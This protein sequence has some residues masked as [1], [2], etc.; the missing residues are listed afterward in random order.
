MPIENDRQAIDDLLDFW[1]AE[2]T[3]AR[4]YQSTDAFDEL[5]WDRFGDLTA[6]AAGGELAHWEETAKGALAVC[7]LLD[8]MPRNLHRGTPK[9]FETDPEAVA[10]S[11][12]AI[13]RAL[14]QELDIERRKFLYM[15]FMHS[16]HLD[17]Q[18][19]CVALAKALNDENMVQHA[20]EHADIVRRFGRF[21]HRNDI[22]GRESTAEEEAFLQDGAKT[23]GQSTTD[24]A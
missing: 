11:K 10:L 14:D 21:P 17:D 20:E 18:E 5:C 1:F 22:V 3:K 2:E 15:P 24:Q 16:E 9:A 12:R 7:L 8:Q 13:T 4:W 19:R 6:R 23:Y